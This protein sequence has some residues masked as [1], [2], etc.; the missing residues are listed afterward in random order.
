MFL[1]QTSSFPDASPSPT[2]LLTDH[3]LSAFVKDE[4]QPAPSCP[5]LVKQEAEPEVGVA[6]KEEEV[7][8]KVEAGTETAA[9]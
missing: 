6:S 1:L 4:E 3:P 2:K 5:L 8:V 9:S 7:Q